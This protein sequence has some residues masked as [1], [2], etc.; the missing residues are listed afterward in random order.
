MKKLRVEVDKEAKVSA[1]P[2][3]CYVV[4][5]RTL[6]GAWEGHPSEPHL[7]KLC[8]YHLARHMDTI[9]AQAGGWPV[10]LHGFDNPEHFNGHPAASLEDVARILRETGV[11]DYEIVATTLMSYVLIEEGS[12]AA[13]WWAAARASKWIPDCIADWIRGMGP[14]CIEIT[15]DEARE[16]RSWARIIGPKNA[17][18][19]LVFKKA[20]KRVATYR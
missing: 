11:G 3:G 20:P 1:L 18:C 8:N 6:P 14:N 12:N 9:N 5:N 15:F 2:C 7:V 17:P 19:P 10:Y 13:D 16:V 4:I